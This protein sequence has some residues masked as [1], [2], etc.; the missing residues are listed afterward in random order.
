MK[1]S[2]VEP[3]GKEPVVGFVNRGHW[4]KHRGL[5]A[6]HEPVYPPPCA[7]AVRMRELR[8]EHRVSLR[9]AAAALGLPVVDVGSL[10][11][12]RAVPAEP[13]GWAEVH[14][15]IVELGEEG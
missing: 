10:E 4:T 13:E 2:P 3:L 9:Q 6:W 1:L 5:E 14:K 8:R 7:E 15:R 11:R 12:G